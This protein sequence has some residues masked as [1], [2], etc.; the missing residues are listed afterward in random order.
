MNRQVFALKRVVLFAS[1]LLISSATSAC[2][3]HITSIIVNTI[4]L[5]IGLTEKLS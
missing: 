3:L 5:V 1:L 2:K 4:K